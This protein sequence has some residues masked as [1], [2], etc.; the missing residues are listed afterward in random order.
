MR[1]PPLDLNQDKC[2]VFLEQTQNIRQPGDIQVSVVQYDVPADS[3]AVEI[4]QWLR[5]MQ[6]D[7]GNVSDIRFPVL[8]C[9][10][11]SSWYCRA[12]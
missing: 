2:L 3:A 12:A 11:Q 1:S 7:D 10:V 9:V 4:S 5:S 8:F 6:H